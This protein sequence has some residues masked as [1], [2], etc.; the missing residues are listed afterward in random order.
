[1][2]SNQ[3]KS[4]RAWILAL[5]MAGASSAWAQSSV[6]LYGVVDLNLEHINNYSSLT[7]RESG[8]PGPA[9]SRT[10]MRSGGLTGS[11]WG[12]R[13]T[14]DLGGGLKAV[15]T[16]ESGVDVTKGGLLQGGRAFGRQSFVGLDGSWG[17]FTMGRQYTSMFSALR[18]FTPLAYA[19][20]YE[21]IILLTGLNFRSDNTIKWEQ[22]WGPVRALAHWTFKSGVSGIN[23]DKP[24]DAFRRDSGFG[25]ALGYNSPRWSAT[26]AYDQT[27]PSM[28]GFGDTGYG[29]ARKWMLAANWVQGPVK[30]IGGYRWQNARY[31]D[32]SAFLRDD[33]MWLGV[34]YQA[35][36][37]WHFALVYYRD[38]IKQ[39]QRK[40]GTGMNDP[41]NPWQVSFVTSH[42]LSK[43][44]D[45]YLTAA[46]AKHAGLNFDTSPINY[47]NGYYL[48]AGKNSML[49]YA[50]GIRHRF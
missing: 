48:G 10:S 20:Q 36:A 11:Q 38:N 2:H 24:G 9:G 28:T 18:P 50:F 19:T 35:N 14:E 16:L 1:M 23:S 17:R 44:T 49:G 46:Y 41:A 25:G 47:A 21:P 33:L 13:G 34:N 15:F 6:T 32:G 30:L 40:L 27:H 7:P 45:L 37:Q 31:S 22:N 3:N 29:R 5:S 26:L 12:M 4:G 42:A 39:L 8:Y 43:R